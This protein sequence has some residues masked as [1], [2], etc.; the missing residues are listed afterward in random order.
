MKKTSIG[1]VAIGM[2]L[3][4]SCDNG[5]TE[6]A[7]LNAQ[8]DS[9]SKVS[10]TQQEKMDDLSG[11]INVVTESLDSIAEQEELLMGGTKGSE[12]RLSKKELKRR[13]KD[14]ADLLQRQR[15]RIA[16]LE[17]SLSSSSAEISKFKK[18]IDFLNSQLDEKEKAIEEMTAELDKRNTNI[19]ELTEK[20]QHL[21]ETNVELNS[22]IDDQASKLKSNDI[23]MHTCYYKIGSKKALQEAGILT[24][25]GLFTKSKLNVASIDYSNCSKIDMRNVEEILIP[26]KKPK[27]LTH[28]PAG[29]YQIVA[30]GD[31]SVLK[32]LNPKTFWSISNVLIIQTN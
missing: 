23:A 32:I 8:L 28:M 17:S 20:V 12:G 7:R 19:K 30:S 9:I 10:M 5:K 14:F 1:I 26:S 24:K 27:I 6:I 22:I 13:L 16:S 18:V 29:S 11:M 4:A 21:D 3:L 15:E 31:N 25:G 2:L